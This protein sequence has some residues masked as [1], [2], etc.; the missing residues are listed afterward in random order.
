MTES[1]E[2]QSPMRPA[3]LSFVQERKGLA[4]RACSQI[5]TPVSQAAG[6]VTSKS[7]WQSNFSGIPP[8]VLSWNRTWKSEWYVVRR[9]S[10]ITGPKGLKAII[11]RVE[12]T[13]CFYTSY[14]C[15]R[16]QVCS[17]HHDNRPTNPRDKLLRQRR[18]FHQGAS[19]LRRWQ[20]SASEELSYGGLDAR[21]F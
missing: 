7:G 5:Q 18:H 15:Y 20:A 3:S 17:A 4:S 10:C 12:A 2:L 16:V 6:Q 9:V 13:I 1:G 19:R 11:P 8:P 21:F 14:L